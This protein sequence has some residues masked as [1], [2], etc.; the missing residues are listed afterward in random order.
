M[1]RSNR[2]GGPPSSASRG[3]GQPAPPSAPKPAWRE[4][5]DAWGGYPIFGSLA[6]MVIIVAVLIYMNRAGATAGSGDYQP[7]L[8]SQVNGR[9]AGNPDAPVKI[10]EFADFQC[11]FCKRFA[12]GPG[13]Q[14]LEEFVNKGTVSLQFV[15]F[16]F[17][18]EESKRAAEA[19]ECAADQGRFWDYHDLLFVRQGVENSGVYSAGNL[20]GLAGELKAQFSNFDARKF[21][22]C[23]DSGEKRAVVEQQVKQARDAGVQS[24]PSFLINGTPMSGVHPI[25][26]FRAVIEAAQKAAKP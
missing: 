18:G 4:S 25:E 9:T 1:G 19:A 22:K 12:D 7:I 15:S 26:T 16:A 24:T 6:V 8:R 10:V 5:F 3:T 13:K 14:L 17:L 21:D 23:L 2:R 20:K 11:P